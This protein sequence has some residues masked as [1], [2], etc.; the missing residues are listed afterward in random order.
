MRI[1]VGPDAECP[2]VGEEEG[3]PACN[4]DLDRRECYCRSGTR[5]P[6]C[7]LFRAGPA[8]VTVSFHLERQ[9]VTA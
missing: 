3:D 4:I 8:G 2:F 7:P 6:W 1:A 9:G 5:A